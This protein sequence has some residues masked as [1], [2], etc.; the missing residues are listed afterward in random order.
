MA[1]YITRNNKYTSAKVMVCDTKNASVTTEVIAIP[2]WY[3]NFEKGGDGFNACQCY[4]GFTATQI[5]VAVLE[6]KE[7]KRK[8]RMAIEKWLLE[9]EPCDGTEDEDED[10]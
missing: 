9:S 3:K 4:N 7:E 10:E 1:K 8:T 2:N 5:M 6:H